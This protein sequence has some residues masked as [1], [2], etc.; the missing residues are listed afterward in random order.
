MSRIQE[1]LHRKRQ[2]IE[3][4]KRSK[5]EITIPQD[6]RRLSWDRNSFRII[7][8]LKRASLSAGSIRPDL[9]P[10]VLAKSYE[11]AGAAA[12]SVLT[13]ENF[14]HGSLADLTAVRNVVSLPLL[15]K[16]FILDEIQ[17]A[18][19]KHAG[20]SFVLL[21]ARFLEKSQL[22]ALARYCE[23]IRMNVLV[24]ITNEEDLTKIDF[25]VNYLGVNSRDLNSLQV[26]I[27]KFQTL[28]HILPDAYL[29]AESGI[30]SIET[31]KKVIGL[32][33]HGALIG[34]H[35]LRCSDPAEELRE[36]VRRG[37]SKTRLNG[38]PRVKVCGITSQHDAMLAIDAGAA[39]LGFI[40]AESPR[41]ILPETLSS[42]R[43]Q[44]PESVLCVGVFKGQ[45]SETIR[46]VM[47]RHDLNVAQVY[48][49]LDPQLPFWKA[50]IITS[51]SDFE[52][53]ALHPTTVDPDL[54][55]LWDFKAEEPELSYLWSLAS[56]RK[57]FALAGGLHPGNVAKAVE[58]CN[59]EWVDVARGVEQSPGIKN[60]AKLRAF[61]KELRS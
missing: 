50:R 23:Q 13:E 22:K 31:L 54:E 38:I 10:N 14:F 45:S 39:A 8:E 6:D 28:R 43:N 48:D 57:I 51:V 17:I 47:K 58:I 18:Q 59:P 52:A 16:D 27:T 25:P 5:M 1:L 36:F 9:Q 34:E 2:Q 32:G 42:F 37:G 44:I 61:M 29:I 12:L 49:D 60:E 53:R 19:A 46:D 30:N 41:R 35:F 15:Q 55:F 56:K 4:L 21:I 26:D 3:L 40:F 7:A 24:E 33:Y 11:R 20:A